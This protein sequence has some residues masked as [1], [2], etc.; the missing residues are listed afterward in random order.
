MCRHAHGRVA[1]V[2]GNR[3]V[4]GRRA[5]QCCLQHTPARAIALFCTAALH[6]QAS[7]WAR[8]AG[9]ACQVTDA[10]ALTQRV[11]NTQHQGV[12]LQ[13]HPFSYASLSQLLQQPP[14]LCV[15]LDGVTDPGNL[16][17]AIRTACAFGAQ[18][19]VIPARN[20]CGV[21]ATVEKAACGACAQLPVVR[22]ANLRQALLQLQ[23]AG[24][25]CIGADERA[26]A[27]VW[28]VDMRKPCAWVVGGEHQGIRP[29]VQ[30]HCDE[31]VRIPMATSGM[32]L[33]AADAVTLLLYETMRQRTSS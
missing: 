28:Q 23:Q 13:V 1:P 16:G 25:W 20:S 30:R 4:L 9:I 11:A 12:A 21:T 18:F 19:L 22:V 33:N 7:Q 15:V 5:V 32:D 27:S 14:Q 29:L 8:C 17:R 26:A 31:M 6:K 2:Q 3:Y 24:F 10:H